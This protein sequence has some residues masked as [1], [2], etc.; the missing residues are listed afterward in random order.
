MLLYIWALHIPGCL[1]DRAV[2]LQC[3]QVVV[4]EWQIGPGL[5]RLRGRKVYRRPTNRSMNTCCDHTAKNERE[6]RKSM[7][8]AS[9]WQVIVSIWILK[10]CSPQSESKR[11][12]RGD[13]DVRCRDR[14]FLIDAR[15]MNE[16]L[17]IKMFKVKNKK[18]KGDSLI[19]IMTRCTI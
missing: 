2:K 14:Q 9:H 3:H 16:R 11:E 13:P 15:N 6:G 5:L 7:A 8:T 19:M 18:K 1:S 17:I 12:Q 10:P 4:A